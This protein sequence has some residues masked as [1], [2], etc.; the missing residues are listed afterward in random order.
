MK[1]CHGV[2]FVIDFAWDFEHTLC[3]F[4]KHNMFSLSI[5]FDPSPTHTL[6]ETPYI[7]EF[8]LQI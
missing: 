5:D 4:F 8:S 2:A 6:L 1:L 3:I 7:W